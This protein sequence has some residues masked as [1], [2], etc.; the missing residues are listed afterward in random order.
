MTRSERPRRSTTKKVTYAET[1]SRNRSKRE[2]TKIHRNVPLDERDDDNDP[3]GL[4]ESQSLGSC[5]SDVEESSEDELEVVELTGKSKDDRNYRGES[6]NEETTTTKPRKPTSKSKDNVSSKSKGARSSKP[7]PKK[8]GNT[9]KKGGKEQSN[10]EQTDPIG[11]NFRNNKENR[12]EDTALTFQRSGAAAK[13]SLQVRA[14]E[15]PDSDEEQRAIIQKLMAYKKKANA[16]ID[17]DREKITLLEDRNHELIERQKQHDL[18]MKKLLSRG[19]ERVDLEDTDDEANFSTRPEQ[20]VVIAAAK[21]I[22]RSV[23]FLNNNAQ[24]E[25]FGNMVMDKTNLPHLQVVEG[26]SAVEE[27][28]TKK[29]REVFRAKYE[30]LWV[31]TINDQRNYNQ[32]SQARTQNNDLALFSQPMAHYSFGE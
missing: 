17:D 30:K 15:S 16:R 23:K 7:A 28:M 20:E 31:K 13:A 18:Q 22:Y 27:L 26:M 12:R 2:C 29:Q 11:T 21:H 3:D 8:G 6:E 1:Q 24:L 4:N 9:S 25:T 14:E 19:G 32:V 10:S 5:Y